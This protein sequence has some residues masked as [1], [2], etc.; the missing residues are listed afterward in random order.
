M[1]EMASIR[2]G[3]EH[4]WKARIRHKGCPAQRKAFETTAC[5]LAW[6]RMIKSEIDRGIVGSQIIA[7][8]RW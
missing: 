7:L 4:P 1:V 3:G 2:S 6:A 8:A 5:A